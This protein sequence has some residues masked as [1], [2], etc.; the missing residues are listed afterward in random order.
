MHEHHGKLDGPR[1][2]AGLEVAEDL[3]L[4]R[5]AG[6]PEET[7]RLAAIRRHHAPPK[8][9][10]VEGSLQ[11]QRWSPRRRQRR[12]DDH[13][14]ASVVVEIQAH[15]GEVDAQR[16]PR[17]AQRAR[18]ADPRSLQQARRKE[19][20]GTNDDPLGGDDRSFGP[21]V[22]ELDPDSPAAFH[23]HAADR[24]ARLNRELP[25]RTDV[26]QIASGAGAGA[27]LLKQRKQSAR[28]CL[29]PGQR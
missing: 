26:G 22:S 15:T 5:R 2:A 17:G 3:H 13:R 8:Q 12:L 23:Q 11:P 9:R 28:L 10:V 24:G 21:P 4:W 16:D 18:R 7:P 6:R 27:A 25:R 19:G 1:M 29:R 14:N 20:T